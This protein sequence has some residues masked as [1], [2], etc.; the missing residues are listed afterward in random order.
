MS[1]SHTDLIKIP[2]VLCPIICVL[3]FVWILEDQRGTVSL[4]YH[5]HMCVVHRFSDS[6]IMF[7][8]PQTY[9]TR[10]IVLIEA[11]KLSYAHVGIAS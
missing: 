8:V 2:V 5:I 9:L 11:R 4:G 7:E 6:K 3:N 1:K 10:T